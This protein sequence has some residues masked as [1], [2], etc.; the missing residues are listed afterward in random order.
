[1]KYHVVLLVLLLVALHCT[2]GVVSRANKISV[3]YIGSIYRDMYR[4]N[5]VSA[6]LA[7]TPGI[8]V[9]HTLTKPVFLEYYLYR[10]GLSDL[11]EELAIDYVISDTLVQDRKFFGIQKSMGYAITNYEGIRFAVLC[12]L[13][14][15][16]IKDQVQLSLVQERNDV[17]WVVDRPVLDL[18]PSMINFYI[19]NRTL[20]DTS[21]ST[22]KVEPDTSLTRR[23]KEF[24]NRIDDEIHRKFYV[25]GR[26]DEHVL[27][28]V[29]EKQAVNMIIYP[30]DLFVRAINADSLTL[31]ELMD[32]VAFEKKFR[33]TEMNRDE[34]S[35]IRQAKGLLQWG[36]AKDDNAVLIPDEL[37]GKHIF[38]FY[39]EKE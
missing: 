13:D 7:A 21:M 3:L 12:S 29:A 18:Q 15:M 11:L 26:V 20:S 32:C 34:V 8:K 4:E 38:D 28:L 24:R 22:I 33:K 10:M 17:V 14:P 30:E 19:S 6:G 27:S 16:T 2:S 39:Y 9:A 36:N 25:G 1:V 31:H 23:I 35:E 37:A 5:P